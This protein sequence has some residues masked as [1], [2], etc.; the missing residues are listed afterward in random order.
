[1][2][3]FS[4][5]ILLLAFGI[6]TIGI[7]IAK[8]EN[9]RGKIELNIPNAPTPTTEFNLVDQSF[10]RCFFLDFTILDFTINLPEYGINFTM[11]TPEYGEYAEMLDGVLI[12]SYEKDPRILT[13][14]NTHFLKILKTEKW[15]QILKVKDHL[16]VSLLFSETPGILNGIFVSFTD[17]NSTTFVNIYGNI[18]IQKLG[19]LFQKLMES[20]PEFLKNIRIN[21]R[22]QK[23]H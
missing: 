9:I 22:N 3:R 11:D 21:T 12:R 7:G 14:M 8:T 13:E 19:T 18:D 17:V 10:F 20:E 16:N 6:F 1:M 2:K 15:E 4:I 23:D 5:L